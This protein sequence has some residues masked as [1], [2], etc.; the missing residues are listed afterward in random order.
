MDNNYTIAI[1]KEDVAALPREEFPGTIKVVD[2]R[3]DMLKA[4]EILKRYPV[5][6]F[7]TESRPIFRKGAEVHVSLIQI[8][9]DD[10]CFLFRVRKLDDVTPLSQIIDNPRITKIGLSLHDDFGSLAHSYKFNP[11]GFIDIQKL[12]P[13]YNISNASLQKIYAILFDMRI[14]KSQQLSNWDAPQ[15][16][17]AQQKYAALDAWACIQIYRKLKGFDPETSKYKTAIE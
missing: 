5:L 9:A 17:E 2:T 16:T 6:G 10:I 12:V 1:S 11:A 3:V 8:S 15:L 7:D 13:S 14:S 4:V